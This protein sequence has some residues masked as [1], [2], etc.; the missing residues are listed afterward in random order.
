MSNKN[1]ENIKNL[2][3][4]ALER[5]PIE[6][7]DFLKNACAGNQKMFEEIRQLLDSFEN[8]QE[9]ME[10][11]AIGEVAEIIVGEKETSQIGKTIGRY[12]IKSLLGEGGMGK[13]YLAEDTELERLTALKILSPLFLKDE[14]RVNRFFQEAKSASALNHPNIL[15]VYEIGKFEESFFIATEYIKGET[16]RDVQNSKPL[17]IKAITEISIQISSALKAAHEAKIIHR[18]IKPENI[19]LRDDGLIKVLDFGLA[20]LLSETENSIT[21]LNEAKKRVKTAPGTVLGTVAYMSPEQARGKNTDFRT[22]IWSFGVVLY[23]ML[24]GD[25]PFNGET[26]SDTIAEILT[27]EP[28]PLNPKIHSQLNDI[29]IKSLKKIPDE[30]YQNVDYLLND[31]KFFQSLNKEN[32][33][34]GANTGYR[35][36]LPTSK[37]KA[38]TRFS[39]LTAPI[40]TNLRLRPLL[41]FSVFSICV[42][43]M[44][45]GNYYYSKKQIYN[46]KSEA[47]RWFND[48]IDAAR[49][50]NTYKA[51]KL[52]EQS[53]KEDENFLPAHAKLAEVFHQLDY[54][55]K[56]AQSLLRVTELLPQ[57]SGLTEKDENYLQAVTSTVRRN[58][59][60]AVEKYQK[61]AENSPDNEKIFALFD[62]AKSI[63]RTENTTRA[64]EIY[65]EILKR[66]PQ[67]SAAYLRLGNIYWLKGEQEKADGYFE[68]AANIFNAQ[69]NYDSLG[70]LFYQKG[71][72]LN[73]DEKLPEARKSLE[74]SL[75]LSKATSN[76]LL[77]IKTM[78]DIARIDV[79]LGDTE[80]SKKQIEEAIQLS[81]YEQIENLTTSG[82]IDLGNILYFQGEF[83]ESDKY[84]QQAL[85]IARANGGKRAEAYSLLSLGNLYLLRAKPT[86]AI[87]Y[88]EPAL[89]FFTE[90][91]FIQETSQSL[92]VLGNAFD[93]VG[94]YDS[95]L[96]LLNK[97]KKQAIEENDKSQLS[98]AEGGIAITLVH[99]EK[100][101]ESLEHSEK[102]FQINQEL[103]REQIGAYALLYKTQAL[104]NLGRLEEAN[105]LLKSIAQSAEKSS[106]KQL[107]ALVHLWKAHAFLFQNNYAEAISE[108]QNAKN[109]SDG[110]ND[111]IIFLA[112][113][114]SALA[115]L[116][117][118]SITKA[119]DFYQKAL[120]TSIKIEN[121]QFKAFL[122]LTNAEI[123]LT[124][125]KATESLGEALKAGEIFAKLNCTDSEFKAF[126]LAEKAAMKL[127][128]PNSSQY[129]IKAT[130]LLNSLEKL[131]GNQNFQSYRSRKDFSFYHSK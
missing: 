45:L 2:F 19:M 100:Y 36:N 34:I 67:F 71:S 88:V 124:E 79:V 69:S 95:A 86:E 42:S 125:N 4:E 51:K 103:D 66:D 129:Q 127:T 3:N 117:R 41:W 119:K 58:F 64:A 33:K 37:N 96:E 110:Q 21:K 111:D 77:Q 8:D 25:P 120:E 56:A 90:N 10:S 68:Q 55:D 15:T 131:W 12:K 63:E 75:E 7:E 115:E 47:L 5:P 23:E 29:V 113:N 46:P 48:G 116:R 89:K 109:V 128:D 70:E 49:N 106:D 54:E 28:A 6:R 16:L 76:P 104:V 32:G 118:S 121:P 38:I 24:A 11:P 27:S 102:S 9:F 101:S 123:L 97:L 126:S 114:I 94:K 72:L 50:G 22:D 57:L 87:N 13:V 93:A 112:N 44:F 17:S 80:K 65:E 26:I 62:L 130:N 82:L 74:K 1:W 99:L 83:E 52:F 91:N 53:I 105:D 108:S 85:G 92:L 30:R 39:Q 14:I 98:Y 35:E 81:R 73:F 61:I 43:L 107:S 59:Q 84:L 78:L 20:K 122:H 18:D 31:L 60:G 40:L